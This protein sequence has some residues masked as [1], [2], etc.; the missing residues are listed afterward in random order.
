MCHCVE[1]TLLLVRRRGDK[2]G[3]INASAA[4]SNVGLAV[5]VEKF[6]IRRGYS[7]SLQGI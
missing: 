4:V 6:Q 7:L 5:E 2:H 3:G 1:N